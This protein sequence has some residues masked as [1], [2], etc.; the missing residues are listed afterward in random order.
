MANVGIRVPKMNFVLCVMKMV[1]TPVALTSAN[2]S[3]D[4]S[5]LHPNEFEHLWPNIHG[6]FYTKQRQANPKQ[7][8]RNGSTVVDLSIQGEFKILRQGD[9]FRKTIRI[10]KSFNLNERKEEV[11]QKCQEK[12]SEHIKEVELIS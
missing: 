5:T 6:I 4:R 1:N 12:K 8:N 11:E 2:V 10:L 7:I 9:D 3:Q